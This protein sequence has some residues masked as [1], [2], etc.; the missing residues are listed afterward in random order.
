MKSRRLMTVALV[1]NLVVGG[2]SVSAGAAS[3]DQNALRVKARAELAAVTVDVDRANIMF[4][5]AESGL[6]SNFTKVEQY[7]QDYLVGRQSFQD[8]RYGEALQHLRKA[9]ELIRSQPDWTESE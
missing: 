5:P 6:G 8:G 9:D 7:Q 4:S 1:S 2:V 3:A